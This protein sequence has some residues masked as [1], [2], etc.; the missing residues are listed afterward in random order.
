MQQETPIIERAYQLAGLGSCGTVGEVKS[1]LKAEGY[2][3]VDLYLA[4]ATLYTA[5]RRLCAASRVNEAAER[6]NLAAERNRR[7]K[8][9]PHPYKPR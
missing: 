2:A 3:D 5:L 8:L 4:G 1:K 9:A 6:A 7:G